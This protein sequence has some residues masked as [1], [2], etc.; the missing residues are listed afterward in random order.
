[1]ANGDPVNIGYLSGSS[2]CSGSPGYVRRFHQA[3]L[4]VPALPSVRREGVASE[5]EIVVRE[6]ATAKDGTYYYVVNPAMEQRRAVTMRLPKAG[7]V[8]DL[9]SRKDLD[10]TQLTLD[11]EPGELRSYRV[12]PAQ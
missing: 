6:I 3:F 11:L 5:P 7:R 8:R 9:V 2:F 1:V 4:S 12:A 10:T